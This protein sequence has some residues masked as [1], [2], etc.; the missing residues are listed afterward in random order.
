[1]TKSDRWAAAR[2]DVEEASHHY[3][4][5]PQQMGIDRRTKRFVVERCRSW[6]RPGILLDL[7]YVDGDWCDEALTMGCSVDIV[8]G[9]AGHVERARTKYANAGGVRI[10]HALFQEF[11]PDRK[12]DT[13]I[14]GDM[15]RYVPDPIAFLVRV[16]EWL[17]PNGHLIVTVPNVRSLHRRIGAVMGLEATPETPNQRDADVGNLRGYDRYQLRAELGAAGF[18]VATLNGCFLKPLSSSQMERWSDELLRAFLTIGDE[19]EDYCWFIYAMCSRPVT[20]A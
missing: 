5:S 2:R 20:D 10:F 8:E 18:E 16:R 7:G 6:I 3:Y 1:M 19:L 15:L 12:Y 14:A 13:V 17:N 9:A 4:Y 11:E